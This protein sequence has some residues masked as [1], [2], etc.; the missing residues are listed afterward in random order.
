MTNQIN[1]NNNKKELYPQATRLPDGANAQ[2]I[3]LKRNIIYYKF[4]NKVY[5]K[6]EANIAF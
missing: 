5:N 4:G 3:T 1:Y 6:L 2:A